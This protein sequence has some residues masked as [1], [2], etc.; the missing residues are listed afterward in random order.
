MHYA[1]DALSMSVVAKGQPIA[2]IAFRACFCRPSRKIA[3]A[4]NATTDFALLTRSA[5]TAIAFCNAARLSSFTCCLCGH[6][7]GGRNTAAVSICLRLHCQ[8]GEL[9]APFKSSQ[10]GDLRRPNAGSCGVAR[11]IR[12]AFRH[13]NWSDL[14]GIAHDLARRISAGKIAHELP[15]PRLTNGG[16]LTVFGI[17]AIALVLLCCSALNVQLGLPTF[18]CGA[19]TSANCTCI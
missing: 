17:A 10:L 12:P 2:S 16:R 18:I 14:F 3:K 1:Y 5:M 4:G 13:F 11:T 15:R 19:V 9:R 8:R 7:G 6:A